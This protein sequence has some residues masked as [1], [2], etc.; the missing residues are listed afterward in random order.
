M[1]FHPFIFSRKHKIT[2]KPQQKISFNLYLEDKIMSDE[3]HLLTKD[4]LFIREG[5]DDVDSDDEIVGH[6]VSLIME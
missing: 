6:G 1:S 3:T 4:K 2:P 5:D